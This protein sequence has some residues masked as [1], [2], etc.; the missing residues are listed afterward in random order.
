MSAKAEHQ[1][2]VLARFLDTLNGKWR[3]QAACD[4][5][6]RI[7]PAGRI[8]RFFTEDDEEMSLEEQREVAEFCNTACP[9]QQACLD[10]ALDQG[11]QNWVWGGTTE[12]ERRHLIK[13]RRRQQKQSA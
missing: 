6:N 1:R 4:P 2:R 11:D 8:P 5:A 3:L 9:V 13:G 12:T 7:V 10:F